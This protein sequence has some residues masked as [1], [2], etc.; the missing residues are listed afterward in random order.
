MMPRRFLAY[1]LYAL[2]VVGCF[3]FAA[4]RPHALQKANTLRRADHVPDLRAPETGSVDVERLIGSIPLDPEGDKVWNIH[5]EVRYR[6][7]ILE[8]RGSC[9][10]MAYGLAYRLGREGV[11]YQIIHMLDPRAFTRGGGHTVIRLAYRHDGVERVG[12][13]DVSFGALLVGASGPLDVAE[14]EAAPVEGWDFIP[15]NDAARF[16]DYHD[17]GFIPRVYLGYIP[18]SEV[19]DYYAFLDRVY[20]SFGNDML[21]KYLFDGLA[22]LVGRLPEIF[23]VHYDD[24][25]AGREVELGLA[26]A[27]LLGLRS[28]VVVLPLILVLEGARRRRRR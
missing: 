22:L 2:L 9:S 17:D 18:A 7:T 14:V 23:V 10:Q 24:L 19:R 16:P 28:A 6:Q 12:L 21:E 4:I 11:D 20:F 25:V 5:P 8:G 26:R 13:I 3:A 1:G 27:S 15:L